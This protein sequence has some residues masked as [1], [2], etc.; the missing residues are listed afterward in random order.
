MRIAFAA[1]LALLLAATPAL[2]G[3]ASTI[4]VGLVVTG[5]FASALVGTWHSRTAA[6][7]AI[8]HFVVAGSSGAFFKLVSIRLP[9]TSPTAAKDALS[10]AP[11]KCDLRVG[12][13]IYSLEQTSGATYQMQYSVQ[14]AD[15]VTSS[16]NSEDCQDV[17]AS[18]LSDIA[19]AD[20]T[21][22]L[23]LSRTG[24]GYLID[25]AT[26]AEYTRMR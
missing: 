2:A 14:S 26:G 17:A 19:A 6:R 4:N 8:Y 22:S 5:N 23:I 24:E 13:V 18:Y 12:G 21:Q 16:T 25:G 11:G 1:A 9:E 15:V 10:A 3:R 7:G 20:G